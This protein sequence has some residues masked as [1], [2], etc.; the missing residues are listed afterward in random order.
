MFYNNLIVSLKKDS[1]PKYKYK[2]Y[3]MELHSFSILIN[4]YVKLLIINDKQVS[5]ISKIIQKQYIYILFSFFLKLIPTTFPRPRNYKT[6]KEPRQLETNHK[7]IIISQ[8]W[9]NLIFSSAAARACARACA[10][11]YLKEPL[12]SDKKPA[13]FSLSLSLSLSLSFP[14]AAITRRKCAIYRVCAAPLCQL[15]SCANFSLSRP[16]VCPYRVHTLL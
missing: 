10:L 5:I 13:L 16:P 6:I 12:I 7:N 2:K 3:C 4:K 14:I 11:L 15:S 9:S 1:I 8:R